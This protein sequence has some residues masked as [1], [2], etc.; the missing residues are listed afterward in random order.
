MA[1]DIWSL[2]VVVAWLECGLP[3]YEDEWHKNAVVWIHAI[4]SHV[5]DK[6]DEQGGELLYLLIDSMLIEDPDERSL[7]DYVNAEALKLLQGMA[8]ESDDEGSATPKPSIL[9]VQSVV[10]SEGLNVTDPD[11]EWE[12]PDAPD[13]ETGLSQVL[14]T[15]EA[16]PQ[17]STVDGLLWNSGGPERA[18]FASSDGS[19]ATEL[20]TVEAQTE[21]SHEDEDSASFIARC[22]LGDEDQG[23][24]AREAVEAPR[25]SQSM[26]K[27]SWPEGHSPLSFPR[28]FTYLP[29]ADQQRAINPRPPDHKRSRREGW[30][31]KDLSGEPRRSRDGH[32]PVH[33]KPNTGS[34]EY[35]VAGGQNQ[36]YSSV[37][38]G[39]SRYHKV[40]RRKEIGAEQ[41]AIEK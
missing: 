37:Q 8:N 40:L 2:G 31:S 25:G 1:V 10:E 11:K 24:G 7:A 12:W 36:V 32:G 18:S 15:T 6:Y 28:S 19:E 29:S 39:V 38:N 9:G 4:Q 5:N 13:P 14:E 16:L 27:R 3:V 34:S 17:G 33:E 23:D 22:L 35:R 26:R 20:G 30:M 41:T 21:D